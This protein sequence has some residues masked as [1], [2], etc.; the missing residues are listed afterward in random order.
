[1]TLTFVQ[2]TKCLVFGPAQPSHSVLYCF[3]PA[4]SCRHRTILALDFA[5]SLCLRPRNALS[6]SPILH[7]YHLPSTGPS[8]LIIKFEIPNHLALFF[9]M[10]N[11]HVVSGCHVQLNFWWLGTDEGTPKSFDG[12]PYLFSGRTNSALDLS[13]GKLLPALALTWLMI[14][15]SCLGDR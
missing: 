11:D 12:S 6:S 7:R 3:L 15:F 2:P 14:R 5:Y 9:W 1:M 8:P 4:A 10:R 13:L